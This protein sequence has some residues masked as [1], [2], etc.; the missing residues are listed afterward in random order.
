MITE[1]IA[2]FIIG[3]NPGEIRGE[4]F[5]IARR[6]ITDFAGVALAG[7]KEEAGGIVADC[8]REMGGAVS[9][10]VIGKGFRTAPHLA[11]LANGAMGHALDYDDL[12]FTYG[13][14]PVLLR[15][16]AGGRHRGGFSGK[17]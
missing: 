1:K 17:R 8:V 11:A 6:G 3:I 7:S 16:R 15:H 13:A 4:A 9:S 14:H 12:S 10:C 5:E 2:R